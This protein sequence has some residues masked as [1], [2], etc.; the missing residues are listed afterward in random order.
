MALPRPAEEE[1]VALC[2]WLTANGIDPNTVPLHSEL[3]IVDGVIRFEQY[4]LT[5]DGHK[6]VDPEHRDTAWTRNA[7]APCTVAPPA[8]LNIATT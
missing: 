1:R 7:T 8:E 5:D 4:I 6:Q 2:E 3:S